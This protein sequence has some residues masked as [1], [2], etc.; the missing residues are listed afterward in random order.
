MCISSFPSSEILGRE[1]LWHVLLCIP[2]LF[3][4]VQVL[5]LP[6]L[7]DAPRYLFIEKGDEK[8]CKKGWLGLPL[9]QTLSE[10]SP[11]AALLES[12]SLEPAEASQQSENRTHVIS[13]TVGMDVM[14]RNKGNQLF[15][16]L[17]HEHR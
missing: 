8:A 10:C 13:H 16:Q 3:S 12:K 2:A 15:F 1:D 5:V 14:S 17:R 4:V 11:K 7:P 9:L 6:F